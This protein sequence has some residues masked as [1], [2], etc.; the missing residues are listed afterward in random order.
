MVS[1]TSPGQPVYQISIVT[2][3]ES[4]TLVATRVR[5]TVPF[6]QLGIEH[7]QP[8]SE[9][10]SNEDPEEKKG[11]ESCNIC[12]QALNP[13]SQSVSTITQC[14]HIYHTECIRQWI[15]KRAICPQCTRAVE[16]KPGGSLSKSS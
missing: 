15:A 10:L 6:D 8:V 16:L 12:L 11:L 7:S 5:V 2:S 3:T 9:I 14:G 4:I 1:A 13:E